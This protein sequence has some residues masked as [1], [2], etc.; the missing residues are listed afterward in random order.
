MRPRHSVVPRN[1]P[2]VAFSQGIF[3]TGVEVMG[4]E[5]AFGG[6]EQDTPGIFTT[7]P[8]AAPGPVE[9]RG[10]ILVGYTIYSQEE[11]FG[12]LR[13]MG[14]KYRG[15]R[16]HLL[17]RCAWSRR[18]CAFPLSTLS[19]RGSHSAASS[20]SAPEKPRVP[21]LT[22]A[23]PLRNCNH[24]ADELCF[25]LTGRHAPPWINRLAG[26][27]IACHCLLPRTW[28]PPLAP[29][30]ADEAGAKPLDPKDIEVL[31]AVPRFSPTPERWVDKVLG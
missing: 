24:F 15:N 21:G 16:Y 2:T 23:L 1:P 27:A 4:I 17:S 25:R 9:F 22:A 3:H 30:R 8:G 19:S 26:W 31:L 7:H 14:D 20:E 18:S 6:H 10:S 5:Y 28:V 29:P 11:I 13:E 12:I